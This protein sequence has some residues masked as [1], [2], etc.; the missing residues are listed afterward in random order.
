M[1]I[2]VLFLAN[3]QDLPG[4]LSPTKLAEKLSVVQRAEN[5]CD[6]QAACAL[7]GEDLHEAVYKL[8]DMDVRT[9]KTSPPVKLVKRSPR[10]ADG[11]TQIDFGGFSPEILG[12]LDGVSIKVHYTGSPGGVIKPLFG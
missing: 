3:K 6:V 10:Q 8:A 11:P 2:P 4:A 9:N 5:P 12:G 7:T 1:G